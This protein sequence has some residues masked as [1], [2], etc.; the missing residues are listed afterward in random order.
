MKLLSHARLL[1]TPWTTA[2]QAPPSMG[3]SRQEHW[4]GVPSPSPV[5]AIQQ[6]EWK[7]Y[8]FL[9]SFIL[10]FS[11]WQ[12]LPLVYQNSKL[13]FIFNSL[14]ICYVTRNSLYR[15]VKHAIQFL[16]NEEHLYC[17]GWYLTVA[18]WQ[19]SRVSPLTFCFFSNWKWNN[20]TYIVFLMG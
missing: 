16:F 17:I 19:S 15:K 10:K 3:F 6:H 13:T 20:N 14:S 2:H 4:S 9:H 18:L 1:A 11:L 12:N 7:L 8:S 5:S